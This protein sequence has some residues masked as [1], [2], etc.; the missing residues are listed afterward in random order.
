M[1]ND[2][3]DARNKHGVDAKSMLKIVFIGEPAVD[4]G[5]PRREFFSG[6]VVSVM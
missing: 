5:G 3:V 6:E 2:F 4:D 1:W